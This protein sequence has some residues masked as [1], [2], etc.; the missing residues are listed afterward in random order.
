MRFAAA[1]VVAVLLLPP[2]QAQPKTFNSGGVRLSY[3]DH[4]DGEA[5]VLLHGFTGS[6]EDAVNDRV[7][8]ALKGYRV[9]APDQRGHG[10]SGKPQ[11]PKAYGREMVEDV[12]RLL[13]HAGV[14]KAHVV[15]YSMGAFVAGRL[16]VDHP[17]RLL[18]VTFGGGGPLCEPSNAHAA[19]IAAAAE[20]L[21]KGK[22]L[23]PLVLALL[24]PGQPKPTPFELWVLDQ[25]I[26]R[27]ND[28]K[29]LAAVLRAEA[30]WHVTQKQL[31]ANEVPVQFVHGDREVP[32]LKGGVARL[33][34]M[35]RGAAVEVI[36]GRTHFDTFDTPEFRRAVVGFLR[37]DA[38]LPPGAR[39]TLRTG[40]RFAAPCPLGW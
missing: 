40:G 14:K 22:G 39:Q 10:R 30:G 23:A 20:S 37:A 6:S 33:A 38:A 15:G 8:A 12:V 24:P 2:L 21:E 25:Q 7:L 1:L 4:G 3:L 18:S 17:D 32:E 9:L 29:A 19:T 13:D 35:M 28:P 16:L 34:G 11:N 26:L 31:A 27:T 5:V 36:A